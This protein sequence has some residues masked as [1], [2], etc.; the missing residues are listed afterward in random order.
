MG[1]EKDHDKLFEEL[2]ELH[3]ELKR[4]AEEMVSKVM[5]K[6]YEFKI[7]KKNRV[8]YPV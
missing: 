1:N 2:S 8:V 4:Q 3:K 7:D 5:S 6:P